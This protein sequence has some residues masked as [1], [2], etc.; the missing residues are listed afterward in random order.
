MPLPMV[1]LG[2]AVRY[3]EGSRVPDAFVLG[4]I[5]P[6]AIHMRKGAG[7]EDKLR[8]HFGGKETAPDR[9]KRHYAEWIGRNPGED[10]H[11]YVKGYFAHVLTD[12]LWGLDVYADFKRR[13]EQDGVP[14]SEIKNRYYADTDG[15]DFR[16]YETAAWKEPVWER[17]LQAPAYA[18][19]PLLSEREV[20][21][22]RLRTIRWFEEPA[23]KPQTPPRS[24][25]SDIVEAF[26]ERTGDEVRAILEGWER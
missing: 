6:D 19:S 25:T 15:V 23:N 2:V 13:A 10:W 5:A 26:I 22:W 7:R 17:L 16:L 8:T 14:D 1:H 4:S 24:I 11:L 18:M 20:D 21:A 12:Y 3:F 9:L